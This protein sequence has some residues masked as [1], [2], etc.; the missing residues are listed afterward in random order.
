MKHYGRDRHEIGGHIQH[1][2]GDEGVV[3]FES[4]KKLNEAVTFN[5]L[6]MLSSRSSKPGNSKDKQ[7][8]TMKR[9]RLLDFEKDYYDEDALEDDYDGEALDDD[10]D[11]DAFEE[12]YMMKMH[13]MKIMAKTR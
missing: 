12:D 3:S 9:W 8:L 10:Y 1:E 4:F 6:K 2:S 11:E 5:S 7:L 13:S